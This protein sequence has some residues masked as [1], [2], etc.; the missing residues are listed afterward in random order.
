MSNAI[1]RLSNEF[2]QFGLPAKADGLHC[3]LNPVA[4]KQITLSLLS[5]TLAANIFAEDSPAPPTAASAYLKAPKTGGLKFNKAGN[6]HAGP[7]GLLLVAEAAG[8]IVAIDTGDRGVFK[9][10]I[11]S[12]PDVSKKIASALGAKSVTINDLAVNPETGTIYLSTQR[13]DGLSA[14][15]TVNAAGKLSA[16]DTEKVQWVRAKLNEKLRI[17]RIADLGLATGRILVAGQSNDAF[18]SRIFSLPL[19]L[20]S[21]TAG[22]T[23]STDTYH[24]AHRRWE[25]KAPIQSFVLYEQEGAPYM[26]GSFAC[27]PIAKFPLE[28]LENNGQVKGTS[29][30]ELGSG[31]RPVDMFTYK[32]GGKSWLVTHTMRF[33][34]PFAYTPSKYWAA[35]IDMKHIAVSAKDRTNEKAT[36]RD[37]NVAKDPQG[38]EVVEALHGAIQVD[39]YGDQQAAILREREGKL[40]LEIVRLP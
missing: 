32:S 12:V 11:G 25:T 34:K 22:N 17:S 33:H 6:L 18:R 30:L 9:P 35:R 3:S 10:L 24:V 14:I 31:N 28:N 40:D 23:Y 20:A 38:I 21:G 39:K 2:T 19:P 1:G 8:S 4:M 7:F 5:L 26:V 13:S 36:R 37:R 29:V 27:T 15:L 16:L